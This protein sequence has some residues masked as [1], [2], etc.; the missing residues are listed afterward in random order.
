MKTSTK[1]LKKLIEAKKFS[2]VNS[3]ITEANFPPQ[4]IRST[5]YNLYHFDRY[6]SSEEVI[7][8]MEKDGYAPANIYELLEWEGWN[9]KD[10]VVALA[11]VCRVSGDRRVP[12]L[13]RFDSERDLSLV[14]WDDGWDGFCRFLAVRNSSLGASDTQ[15]EFLGNLESLT[16]S[17]AIELVKKEGYVIYKP[18]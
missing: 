18:I 11:S 2:W 6:I 7:K 12:C 17:R 10:W 9:D 4:K 14:Y 8:E 3:N 13:S 1:S 5:D 16:L 15:K